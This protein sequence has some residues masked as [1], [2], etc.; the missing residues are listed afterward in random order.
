MPKA[1]LIVTIQDGVYSVNGAPQESSMDI[2]SLIGVSSGMLK[3]NCQ[4][5]L[6][7]SCNGC[8]ST[9]NIT[10]VNE[11]ADLQACFSFSVSCSGLF[12][13]HDSLNYGCTVITCEGKFRIF[14]SSFLVRMR[15]LIICSY[16]IH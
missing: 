2:T 6:Q 8:W 5:A 13:A 9:N 7:G 16:L 14:I 3:I 4:P 12:Q 1:P 10:Y 15:H 11:G